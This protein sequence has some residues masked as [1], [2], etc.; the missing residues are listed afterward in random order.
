MCIRCHGGTL[1]LIIPHIGVRLTSIDQ[2][3]SE[4]GFA[5]RG[6]ISHPGD[7]EKGGCL[8]PKSLSGTGKENE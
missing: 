5:A 3:Y 6:H 1:P 4:Q 7:R 8:Y 2:P